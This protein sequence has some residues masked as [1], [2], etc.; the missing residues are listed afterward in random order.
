VPRGRGRWLIPSPAVIA[1][2]D[3][4]K[5]RR[6]WPQRLLLGFN[7]V[8]VVLCLATAG[9]LAYVDDKVGRVRYISL[10]QLT[11]EEEDPAAGGVK[12]ILLTGVDNQAGLDPD[13]PRMVGRDDGLRSDTIM[14]LRVDPDREK[15]ALVSFPRDLWLPLGGDGQRSKINAAL[16][17]GGPDLLIRTISENFGIPINHYVQVNFAQF[18]RVVDVIGGVPV[19][20]DKPVR[21]EWTGLEILEPGCTNLDGKRA[22]DYVRSR[23]LEYYEGDRW[24]YDP[25]ADLSRIDRQQDFIRR[26]LK[27]AVSRGFRNPITLDR[28][29][30]AG[31]DS[32]T[33][34]DGLSLSDIGSLARRFRN[35]DPDLFETYALPVEADWAG[36]A[37]IMRVNETD[38]EPILDVFR[39]IEAGATDPSSVQV[40]VLNG[41]GRTDEGAIVGSA[42]EGIGFGVGEVG[43]ATSFGRAST[44]I[45][46]RPEDLSSAEMLASYLAGPAQLEEDPTVAA[47]GIELTTGLD[48]NGVRRDPRPLPSTSSTSPNASAAGGQGGAGAG[49]TT[50]TRVG[51]VPVGE[52]DSCR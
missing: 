18:Q 29:L 24:Q 23:Y 25:A 14:L 37:S 44:V 35:F 6:T 3:G 31:L 22:L 49:V 1:L 30:N 42:L 26:A 7:A 16:P 39:G 12:N 19:P 9:T 17:I 43:D 51:V 28:L 15:A 20:F 36:D 4:A 2:P 41:T 45:R 11:T 48:Y 52:D 40:A 50:T 21:D 13:D 8:V 10:G 34:D 38:A 32:V 33:V 27:R 5:L 47:A 46:Y